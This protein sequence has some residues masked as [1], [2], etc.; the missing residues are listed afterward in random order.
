LDHF[1]AMSVIDQGILCNATEAQVQLTSFWSK[2]LNE[3]RGLKSNDFK[4]QELPL[5]RIKKVMKLDEDVKMISAEA[6]ALFAKAAEFFISE[7]T[8]RAWMHAEENKRRTLQRND[9]AMAITKYDQFDFLIDIVPREEIR[10]VKR[11]DEGAMRTVVSTDQVQYYIQMAQQQQGIQSQ[12][13]QQPIQI[14]TGSTS[15]Q[16]STVL[17]QQAPVDT[18]SAQII[19]I[20]TSQAGTSSQQSSSA[21]NSMPQTMQVYTQVVTPSGEVQQIP[22][23]LTPSQIQAITLQ[24][25]GKQPNQPIVIQAPVDATSNDGS[26]GHYV[27]QNADGESEHVASNGYLE[28][29]CD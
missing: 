16:V 11:P 20:Q 28:L 19:Q 9:I 15:P 14:L 25:Q 5:A 1:I 23:Q 27:Q 24:M 12:V 8:L 13:I 2:A 6:P 21:V 17:S 3:I 10:P 4:T 18:S 26:G 22:I 7:L 29:T